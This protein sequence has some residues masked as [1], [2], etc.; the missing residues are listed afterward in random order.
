MACENT[1]NL[2]LVLESDLWVT[3]CD[4]ADDSRTADG[5]PSIVFLSD[6]Q[7]QG[8]TCCN[9]FFG[10]YA[11]RDSDSVHRI[12]ITIEG[13]TLTLCPHREQEQIYIEKLRKIDS[14]TVSKDQLMLLDS[15]GHVMLTFTPAS[16]TQ[17]KK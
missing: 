9:S 6:G 5:S 8:Y 13:M 1:P 14:Y 11:T 17:K 4:A 15:T 16:R 3:N 10:S 7:L 12:K 2:G